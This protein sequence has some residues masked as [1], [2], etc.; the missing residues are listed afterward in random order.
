MVGHLRV[1]RIRCSLC[2]AGAFFCSD[3]RVH[4]MFR[5]CENLHLAPPGFVEPNGVVPCMDKK[6]V[7]R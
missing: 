5:H 3:M 7:R 1:M 4:L 6:K 2:E